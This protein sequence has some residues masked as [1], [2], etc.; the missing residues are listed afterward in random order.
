MLRPTIWALKMPLVKKT[1]VCGIFLLGALTVLAGVAKLI[2][3][4]SVIHGAHSVDVT[5][6]STPM[7]YFPFVEATLG[8]IGACLPLFRPLFAGV[9]SRGFM[10]DLQ[11]V[12][13]PTS[14]QSKTLWNNPDDSRAV[15]EWNSS[16][17]TVRYG[18]DSQSSGLKEKGM[19]SLPASSLKM[20]S[21]APSEGPWMKGPKVYTNM[22]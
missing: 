6:F 12:D 5:Y 22:V 11:S 21:N 16:I 9:T 17:S 19:P 18:S 10:R 14:E 8:I 3:I 13:I 1:A 2:V 15:E 4:Q 20:L 7:V